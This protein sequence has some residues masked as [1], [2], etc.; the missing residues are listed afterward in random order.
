LGKEC[1][2]LY[3]PQATLPV[4]GWTECIVMQMHSTVLKHI[5]KVHVFNSKPS[6]PVSAVQAQKY[7]VYDG[8]V[9]TEL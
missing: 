5:H 9:S 7:P 8:C 1:T 2:Q 3:L 6:T 4:D